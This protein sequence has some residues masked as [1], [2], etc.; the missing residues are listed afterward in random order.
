MTSSPLFFPRENRAW[1]NRRHLLQVACDSPL[2]LTTLP[3]R[4]ADYGFPS[5]ENPS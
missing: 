5:V 2:I 1:S 4:N 3:G